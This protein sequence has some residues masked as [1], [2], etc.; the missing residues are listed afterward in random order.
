M[1]RLVN[2]MLEI[3]K[4][5]SSENIKMT[6]VDL[7]EI[8]KQ[9][10][11]DLGPL[12]IAASREIRLIGDEKTHIISGNR[13]AL[14]R[15]VR[16]IVE[17]A[18]KYSPAGTPVEIDISDR[19]VSVKDY[20]AP[21]DEN[22]RGDIFKRFYRKGGRN[23]SGAGLGLSIATKVMELHAGSVYLEPGRKDGNNF[24]LSFN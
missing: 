6:S 2:Q 7:N 14:Y 18:I 10:C 17:N 5:D 12:F 16:N 1:T 15:A 11:V 4:L 22:I 23:S 20:G 9:V 24:V 3:S 19:K 8:V 21:I 13:E